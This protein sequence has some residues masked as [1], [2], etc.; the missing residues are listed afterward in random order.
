MRAVTERLC[1]RPTTTAEVVVLSAL[2][3]D[4]LSIPKA[5]GFASG[6]ISFSASAL[7]LSITVK[8]DGTRFVRGQYTFRGESHSFRIDLET[9]TVVDEG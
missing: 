8:L 4:A 7:D 6:T 2:E 5:G 3:L 1:L 9:G